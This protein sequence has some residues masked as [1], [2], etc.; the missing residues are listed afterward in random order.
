MNKLV[1][2]AKNININLK[3]I[4]NTTQHQYLDTECGVY[5]IYFIISRLK[6]KTCQYINKKVVND[7]VINKFRKVF[8][9][10]HYKNLL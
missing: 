6:G 7:K 5:S 9:N 8:Y 1:N 4:N 2:Q 10:D 3:L